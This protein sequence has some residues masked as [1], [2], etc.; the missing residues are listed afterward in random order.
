MQW[1]KLN[2]PSSRHYKTFKETSTLQK[3]NKRSPLYV[4]TCNKDTN[5]YLLS[6]PY[7]KCNLGKLV[8]IQQKTCTKHL[9]SWQ[10]TKKD[11]QNKLSFKSLLSRIYPWE[12]S[13][14]GHL[15]KR[16]ISYFDNRHIT[17]VIR[18]PSQKE[19]RL[20]WTPDRRLPGTVPLALNEECSF[21]AWYCH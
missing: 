3:R 7:G 18:A 11:N 4:S 6:R 10:R 5:W 8:Q 1:N 20:N 19:C 2:S 16:R 14:F 21:S 17:A 9:F 12:L 15:A 13:L